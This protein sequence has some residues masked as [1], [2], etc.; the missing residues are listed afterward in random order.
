[1]PRRDLNVRQVD[2]LDRLLESARAELATACR[3]ELDACDVLLMSAAVADGLDYMLFV[4]KGKVLTKA[5]LD[6]E[7]DAVEVLVYELA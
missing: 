6:Y 4:P 7:Q 3:N 5:D 1:M 2:T